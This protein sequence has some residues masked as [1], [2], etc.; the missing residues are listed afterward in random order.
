MP[1][2]TPPSTKGK[3]IH[4]VGA[5]SY[6]ILISLLVRGECSRDDLARETGLHINTVRDYVNALLKLKLLF[7]SE[8]REDHSGRLSIAVLQLGQGTDAKRLTI[9][10][11]QASKRWREAQ[12]LRSHQQAIT[13]RPTIGVIN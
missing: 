4:K 9:S 5:L 3:K 11:G 12:A 13:L 7:V 2:P 6:A 10:A 8:W 1:N